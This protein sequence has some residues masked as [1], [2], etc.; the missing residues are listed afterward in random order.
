MGGSFDPVHAGHVALAT[1][2]LEHL[3]LDEV[4][5]VPVGLPWQK[6]RELAASEHRLAMLQGATAHE[7][8][9]VVDPIELNRAGPS[10]T[11][12]TVLALQDNAHGAADQW[13]LIIG[14]DQLANLPTWHG[15]Q[16]LV[17]RVTLAVACRGQQQAQAPQALSAVPFQMVT[18]PL[19]P[20]DASS[21]DI[22][23][24]LARGVAPQSLSPRLLPHAVAD[25]I[26][27]HQLYAPGRPPLNGHP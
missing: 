21:T 9:F 15:W 13:F 4:R 17:K 12:D 6:A 16:D 11:L 19:A 22:R 27:N 14:Q 5:W 20:L 18:L 1:V 24:T 7:P 23:S 26:A 8:R 25:Y 3:L 2:A 10:Y